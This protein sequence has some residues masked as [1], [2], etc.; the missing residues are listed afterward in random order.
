MLCFIFIYSICNV[1]YLIGL[2][3]YVF[4]YNGVNLLFVIRYN[5]IV[6]SIGLYSS[7]YCWCIKW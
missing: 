3:F 5:I 2:Y 7:S 6:I 4:I 1:C